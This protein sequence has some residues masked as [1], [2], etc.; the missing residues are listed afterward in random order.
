MSTTDSNVVDAYLKERL[1]R[2]LVFR[3]VA[4]SAISAI[5]AVRFFA[6]SDADGVTY[7]KALFESF[8]PTVNAVGVVGLLIA[9]LGLM[10]KDLEDVD[11]L[12]Y[13]SSKGTSVFGG[14]VRRLGGDLT[15][16][17]CGAFVSLFVA[18][19]ASFLWLVIDGA[20]A[21]QD[22]GLLGILI[23]Q[24]AF[25]IAAVGIVNLLVRRHSP[26]IRSMAEGREWLRSRRRVV[27]LY[28]ACL[29]FVIAFLALF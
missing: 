9:C 25:F 27:G 2:D 5:P 16:W 17:I 18:M 28:G 6:G 12:A 13:A 15:L 21:W 14:I 8:L 1:H 26:P 19:I 23:A 11:P 3:T 4:W 10:F 29:I 20:A 24:V 7:I 22:I